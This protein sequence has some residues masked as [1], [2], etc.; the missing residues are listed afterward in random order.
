MSR[1]VMNETAPI[2]G[3]Y[4]GSRAFASTVRAAVPAC[5]P[6]RARIGHR[7]GP[8][9]FSKAPVPARAR[10]GI[11]AERRRVGDGERGRL[12]EVREVRDLIAREPARRM[13]RQIPLRVGHPRQDRVERPVLGGQVDQQLVVGSH[14]RPSIKC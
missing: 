4:H 3:P 10:G 6:P 1:A 5:R 2:S 14:R 9:S 11:R 12:V 8:G 13:A 7:A